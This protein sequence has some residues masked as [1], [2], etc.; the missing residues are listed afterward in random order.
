MRTQ[1]IVTVLGLLALSSLAAGCSSSDKPSQV[2]G[3][4]GQGG[5]GTINVGQA[6]GFNVGSTG[7]GASSGN[8]V[9]TDGGVIMPDAACAQSSSTASLGQLTMLVMMDDSGSMSE[10]NKWTQVAEA[11]KTF[12]ADPAAAGLRVGLR[13]FP[14]NEPTM[15]CW[16]TVCNMKNGGQDMAIEACSTALVP[17]D[18]LTAAAAPADAQEA[19]LIAAIPANPQPKT[20]NSGGTPTYAALQGAEN[21][22]STY[23]AAHPTEKVVVVFVTDGEPNGCDER[24]QDIAKIASDTLATKKVETYVIGILGS[25]VS[26]LDKIAVA[27]GTKASIVIGGADGAT[28][29][30]DLLAAFGNIKSANVS[31]DFAV[32]AAPAKLMLSIDNVNVNYTPG[33][34]KASTLTRVKD[35]AGCGTTGGWYYDDN[36]APTQIHLCANTC[37]TVQA[38][39]GAALQVLYSCEPSEGYN[40]PK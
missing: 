21:I 37:T 16:D 35:T 38:D 12:F 7:S 31:C 2:D 22:A 17:I 32:P 6:G 14:S 11:M 5:T 33:T 29:E 8:G 4:N 25:K 18:A 26:T 24:I 10:N 36:A 40:P 9:P 27:G 28:T 39:T 19:K 13:L 34:G 23:A 20:N 3:S 15:G 1:P 30:K